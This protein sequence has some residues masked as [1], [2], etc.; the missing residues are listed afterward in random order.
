MMETIYTPKTKIWVF[1]LVVSHFFSYFCSKNKFMKVPKKILNFVSESLGSAYSV[2][3]IG[4]K[5]GASCFSAYI[6]NE[7]TGFPVALVLYSNGKIAKG[8]GFLALDV[9]ASFEKN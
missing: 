5:D 1:Y 6:K 8:G 3:F 9:I 7:K 2:S 4:E